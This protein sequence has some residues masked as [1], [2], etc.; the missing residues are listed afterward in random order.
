MLKLIAQT[1]KTCWK[2]APQVNSLGYIKSRISLVAGYLRTS[3]WLIPALLLL[4][5]A[6]LAFLNLWL[7][8]TVIPKANLKVA[9]WM[10]ASKMEGMRSL[11]ST[12]AG[13]VLGV[14]GVSF[15][16]TIASLTLASQQFGPRLLRNFMRDRFTQTVL[17]FFVA[18]FFFCM[19]T[20]QLGSVVTVSSYTPV[21]TLFSVL[22]L[23][24]IDL[25]LLVM[26]IHHICVSIQAD[27]IISDVTFEM[28]ER[29]D[30]LFPNAFEET[31]ET[32][33]RNTERFSAQFDHHPKVVRA[34]DDGY[35][36]LI[37]YESLVSYAAE[38]DIQLK[39]CNRAGD[40]VLAG[41]VLAE[42]IGAEIPKD[43]A[44]QIN[45]AVVV[46][47]R[48]TAQQ[49]ME[50]SIRQLV[51]VAL[52]ALSP[53]IN[54]PFTAM[55]CIDRLGTMIN[56][57]STRAFPSAI[58]H[59]ENGVVRLMADTSTFGGLVDA[60]F[61]Q[62]RQAAS[63]HVDVTIRL[64]EIL[65]DV[66]RLVPHAKQ[67]ESL[68]LQARLVKDSLPSGDFLE[69]DQKVVIQRYDALEKTIQNRFDGALLK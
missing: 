5:A 40:H 47:E 37:D 38:N 57:V 17:G 39:L 35:V 41:A 62:I 59:D 46:G 29:I 6:A 32:S 8:V 4:C 52:R 69:G 7:D 16:I 34:K 19:L 13:A 43:L 10:D 53:G 33:V 28:R 56:L 60:A 67:A 36:Q 66:A 11:L 48:R 23:T 18:T 2:S 20:M 12:T 1:L 15:S 49:D 68:Y 65:H 42:V 64:L 30:T 3:F 31:D 63:P 27:S 21:S 24:I 58:H 55:T 22:V 54:D 14:A 51:E 25:L 61:H 45:D 44:Q 26:F 50:Y 9:G